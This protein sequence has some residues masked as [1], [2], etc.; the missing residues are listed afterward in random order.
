MRCWNCG[1]KL[2]AAAQV[3]EY[4]EAPVEEAPTK[5]EV[6]SVREMLASMD[7]ETQEALMEAF[8]SSNTAEEFINA[9]MVGNCP[10][11]GSSDVGDCDN[12]PEIDD[13]C[14]GRCFQCGQLWC[15]D[16]ERLFTKGQFKCE[17]C[18]DE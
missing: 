11:C 13:I 12:D 6:E 9:V 5:E 18:T 1:K 7:D 10:K 3:C 14:V 16:C 8:R 2:P 17:H 15:L 4:C